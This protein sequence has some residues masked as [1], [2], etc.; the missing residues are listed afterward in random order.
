MKFRTVLLIAAFLFC[1][2]TAS[3]QTNST[4]VLG[5]TLKVHST[6]LNEDR[7]IY[8]ALPAGYQSSDKSYPVVYTP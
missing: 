2:A 3:A 8:I 1:L 6:I 4:V 5:E 7:D